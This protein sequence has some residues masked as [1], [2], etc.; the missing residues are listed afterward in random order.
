M[1]PRRLAGLLALLALTPAVA[2]AGPVRSFDRLS[3][4]LRVG[5]VVEVADASGRRVRG[6]LSALGPCSIVV[7]LDGTARAVFAAGEV[8]K[9][10]RVRTAQPSG[11]AHAARAC[12]GR[13][14]E[15]LTLVVAGAA[16]VAHGFRAVFDRPRTV[17]RAPKIPETAGAAL[18]AR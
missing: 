4:V 7:A 15:P 2:D 1:T 9:I 11:V 16:G 18:C 13:D 3:E 5:D 10:R 6:E 14:C 17:Y 8:K 12:D